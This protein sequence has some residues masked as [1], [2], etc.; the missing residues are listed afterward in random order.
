[1]NDMSLQVNRCYDECSC[2]SD[3]QNTIVD[4]R[5]VSNVLE[6]LEFFAAR[7]RPATLAEVA[8]HF[9]WPR[10]STFNLLGTL[11][12]RGYLYEPRAREGYFPSPAWLSLSQRLERAAP[13]PTELQALTAA[14][15]ERTGETAVLAAISGMHVIFVAVVESTQAVRYTA[16]V[17]KIV[18]LQT[19]ATGRALLSMLDDDERAAILKRAVFERHTPTTL[20]NAKAVEEEIAAS[21]RRGFFEG[22]GEYTRDLGG[23]ALPLPYAHRHM[24]VLVAGPTTRVQPQKAKIAKIIKEEFARHLDLGAPPPKARRGA[25]ARPPRSGAA[26]ARSA[27]RP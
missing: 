20:M 17:G 11:L 2:Q 10:S 23:I 27:T 1:M 5:Q 19:T 25:A 18:P 4:V 16:T 15:C 22:V 14:L 3:Q 21:L 13:L 24:A 9:G 7:G 6:L 26:P 8:K 12:N